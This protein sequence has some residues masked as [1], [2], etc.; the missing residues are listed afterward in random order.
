MRF[1]RSKL[2]ISIVL[3]ALAALL[4]FALLPKLYNAQAQTVD[5]VQLVNNVKAGE[6]ITDDMVTTRTVGKFGLDS[7]VITAKD[8]IIGKYAA[9]DLRRGINLYGDMFVENWS[10]VDGALEMEIQKFYDLGFV[11]VT[12]SL[13]NLASSVG[14]EI[15]PGSVVDIMTQ[16]ITSYDEEE[17]EEEPAEEPAAEP[18]LDEFGFPIVSGGDTAGSDVSPFGNNYYNDEVVME[19][20]DTLRHVLVFDVQ[21]AEGSSIS[22][23]RREYTMMIENGEEDNFDASLIPS[24]VTLIV[25][26]EQAVAL[27]NQE[28]RGY[29]HL[30]LVPDMEISEVYEEV[31]A[32]IKAA[33]EE[34]AKKAAEEAAK[35]EAE[36]AAAAAEAEG[37]AEATSGKDTADGKTGTADKVPT[38]TTDKGIDSALAALG[39]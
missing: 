20:T 24:V 9:T 19:Q 15:I 3:L 32:A 25:S 37:E 8:Q 35:A 13:P 36:A 5:A 6:Q 34:A 12:L 4:A 22:E 21:N 27:A 26:P 29:I 38:K 11:R 39:G 30:A 18:E 31:L 23:L 10:E 28:T 14:A 2:F 33:E 17:E 7:A 16:V 1:L